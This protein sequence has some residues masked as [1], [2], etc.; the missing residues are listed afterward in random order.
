MPHNSGFILTH[1]II[2]KKL[3]LE[4]CQNNCSVCTLLQLTYTNPRP[5]SERKV[6][7]LRPVPYVLCSKSLWI[8]SLWFRILFRIMVNAVNENVNSN[9]PL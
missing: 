3:Q 4:Q 2:A 5:L 1:G 9:S 8:E 7:A 6:S